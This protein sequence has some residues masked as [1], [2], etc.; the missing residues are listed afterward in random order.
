MKAGGN[1]KHKFRWIKRCDGRIGCSFVPASYFI[2]EIGDEVIR[3]RWK[4]G[5]EW[6]APTKKEVKM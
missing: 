5:V 4:R 1:E 2:N 6:V 3:Q